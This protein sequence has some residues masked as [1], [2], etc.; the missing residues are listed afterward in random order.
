[1]EHQGRRF[2]EEFLPHVR[3]FPGVR[4]LFEDLKRRGRRNRTR[5]RLR[6]G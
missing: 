1:M 3:A 6:E 2:R 4:A 5:D